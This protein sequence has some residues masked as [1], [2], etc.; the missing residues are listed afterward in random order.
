MPLRLNFNYEAASAQRHLGLTQASYFK[1]VER[2]SSG[3]RINRAADDAAGLSISE[4]L[5]NQVRGLNQA[6]RNA[7]DAISL[8]QTAE[9]ALNNSHA[10]LSRMR[11]L[12]VQAASDTL[13]TADRVSIQA[14]AAQL[15]SELSRIANT[16]QFNTKVLLD[17]TYCSTGLVFEIG[18]NA[19]QSLTLCIGAA[20]ATALG[21]DAVSL[22][23][24]SSADAAI[25][26]IDGAISV[27]SSARGTL[28]AMQN[29]MEHISTFLGVASE[30][31]AAAR[32]R[33]RDADVAKESAEMVRV[34]IL[35][36]AAA[37]VLAQANQA[38]QLALTLLR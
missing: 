3:L 2:L 20:T 11:E 31:T 22:S 7:Q 12:A 28:G 23:S 4:K 16:T 13:T 6:Q 29:R 1:T 8:I 35:Q 18:A 32:S 9:G 5:G 34:Q 33:I 24:Q 25:T 21:V 36:Q 17:G 10:I 15:I 14:E 26:T 37:A 19:G 38:P 27:V 30:N